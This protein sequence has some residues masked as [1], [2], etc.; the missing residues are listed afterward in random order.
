MDIASEDWAHHDAHHDRAKEFDRRVDFPGSLSLRASCHLRPTC[1][2]ISAVPEEG[3]GVVAAIAE[4]HLPKPPSPP[5]PLPSQAASTP[6]S[7]L[8]V[9]CAPEPGSVADRIHKRAAQLFADP[10]FRGIYVEFNP[11]QFQGEDL[12]KWRNLVN[13]VFEMHP[14]TL[15]FV[16]SASFGFLTRSP[17]L[18]FVWGWQPRH[19]DEYRNYICLQE[20][21][22]MARVGRSAGL[23]RTEI[24][25]AASANKIEILTTMGVVVFMHELAHYVMTWLNAESPPIGDLPEAPC[26]PSVP[27]IHVSS[28]TATIFE[29]ELAKER[30][31]REAGWAFEDMLF[32]GLKKTVFPNRWKE[33]RDAQPTDATAYHAPSATD[34]VLC[35]RCTCSKDE[36]DNP[37][38]Q[39]VFPPNAKMPSP[40]RDMFPPL[41]R[42]EP[43]PGPDVAVDSRA[44]TATA[45]AVTPAA[46]SPATSS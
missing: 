24:D 23:F 4:N 13:E 9:D 15:M 41:A 44:A 43:K 36:P 27:H 17:A 34:N 40:P 26:S 10:V 20:P 22:C 7:I 46:V 3:A 37:T 39:V 6:S 25:H 35:A 16:S 8:S 28:A 42:A 2:R 30:G 29:Y 21:V 38:L 32:G 45:T 19:N 33:L 5:P 14:P 18:P 31:G 11:L 12:V 1:C